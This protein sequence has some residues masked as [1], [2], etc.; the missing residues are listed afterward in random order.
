VVRNRPQSE[1]VNV[2]RRI[3]G[4]NSARKAR[5]SSATPKEFLD[6]GQFEA[7]RSANPVVRNLPLLLPRPERSRGD[8]KQSAN[9]TGLEQSSLRPFLVN[10][11]HR[12][13]KREDSTQKVLEPATD[14]LLFMRSIISIA[15]QQ[16]L[17]PERSPRAGSTSPCVFGT[18]EFDRQIGG[19]ALM[20]LRGHPKLHIR[21]D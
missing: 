20:T 12:V 2:G 6:V 11:L 5:S 13:L 4:S 18:S 10:R 1:K 7:N 14:S 17:P 16:W 3:N 19:E 8:R 15:D 21:A 9:V